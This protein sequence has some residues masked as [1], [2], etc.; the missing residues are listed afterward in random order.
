MRALTSASLSTSTGGAAEGGGATLTTAGGGSDVAPPPAA[1]ATFARR[2]VDVAAVEL[3]H[4]DPVVRQVDDRLVAHAQGGA[5]VRHLRQRVLHRLDAGVIAVRVDQRDAA[6]VRIRP[7]LRV[8]GE[9]EQH[10]RGHGET[11]HCGAPKSGTAAVS[12]SLNCTST[13]LSSPEPI[14][15]ILVIGLSNDGFASVIS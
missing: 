5:L 11:S 10:R 7:L 4:A 14:E 1:R 3:R 8:G 12:A 13:R 2:A 6:F 15:I 9:R